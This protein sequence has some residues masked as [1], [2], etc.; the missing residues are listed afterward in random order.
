MNG[1][2]VALTA[3]YCASIR[4][5]AALQKRRMAVAHSPSPDSIGEEATQSVS[6]HQ[7]NVIG[8]TRARLP[9]L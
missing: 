7:Q 1:S 8:V 3:G 9:L 6:D 2:E 5:A 4:S